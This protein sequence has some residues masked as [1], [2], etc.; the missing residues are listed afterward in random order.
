MRSSR[1][2]RAEACEC[3]ATSARRDLGH[4]FLTSAD[5]RLLAQITTTRLRPSGCRQHRFDIGWRCD[6]NRAG[7]KGVFQLIDADDVAAQRAERCAVRKTRDR[8]SLPRATLEQ[9]LAGTPTRSSIVRCAQ[10]GWKHRRPTCYL[11][12]ELDVHRCEASSQPRAQSAH[13]RVTS[14]VSG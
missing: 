11:R 2:S 10:V 3:E 1:L 12:L 4:S 13:D 5:C 6:A 8:W 14:S 7:A 9:R